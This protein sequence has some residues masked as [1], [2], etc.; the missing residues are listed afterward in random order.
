MSWPYYIGAWH[1][2][3]ALAVALMLAFFCEH[4]IAAPTDVCQ[5]QLEVFI[6]ETP[7]HLIGSFTMVVGGRIAARLAELEEIGLNPRGYASADDT[8][9]LD[10]LVGL[11]YR[12]EE[13]SQ[14]IYIAAPD[15]LRAAKTLDA[16]AAP[17]DQIA[18]RTDYGAVLNYT[19]FSA[20]AAQLAPRSF[21]FNGS[22]ATLDARV[23]TPFGTLS[24]T[25]I[26]RSAFDS[27]FDALRL[28]TAF[29]YSDRETLT[30]YRAGDAITGGL[31]WTRPIRIG[32]LQAQRNFALRPDLVTLPLPSASG[33]AAVPST[34][35][36]FVNNVKTSSQDIESGPYR[37]SNVP[38]A[39]GSGEAR[40]VVRDASGRETVTNL[41][42][43]V[44]SRLLGA[45][46]YDFSVEAG[47]PRV[48]Y[49]TIADTYVKQ[50]VMSGS[51]RTGILDWLTLEGHAEAGAGLWNAGAGA[52]LRTGSF[53]VFSAA[54]AGSHFEGKYGLQSYLA[55][56]FGVFGM[57]IQLSSQRSFGSYDDLASAT[58]RLQTGTLADQQT[59]L[60]GLS[61]ANRYG[62]GPA[63]AVPGSLWVS[64]RPPKALD[65]VSI[66][67]PL[68]FDFSTLSASF[69]H[70]DDATGKMSNI[71]SAS[72]SR[73]FGYSV[74]AFATAYADIKD[75]KNCGFLV[76]L[77]IPIGNSALVSSGISRDRN[78]SNVTT[79]AV[80]PL[81]PQPGS[82][83]WRVHDSEGATPDRSGAVAYRSDYARVEVGARQSG[84]GGSATGEVEGAVATMGN[85]I[86]LSNRIDDSFAVIDTGVPG[87]EV[88][89]ENRSVGFT[90]SNGRALI[91]SLHS[92]QKN[93]IAIDTRN[94]PVDAD[95]STTEEI[96]AP[97]DR[98]G[99]RLDFRVRTNTSAAILVLTGPDGQP[100][101]AGAQ[102][103]VEGGEGFVV[104]YD[105]RAWVKGLA[106]QNTVTV[107]LSGHECRASFAYSAQTNKQVVI[108]ARCQ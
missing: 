21:A 59:L 51:G 95:I 26:L 6:N 28:D 67:L 36:V 63:G 11:S 84:K 32:G 83:G 64:A 74:T 104:G 7:T 41:P 29:A 99:V 108:P 78:G 5:L 80:K 58:A 9:V 98:S 79:D 2:A 52:I 25:G 61:L 89:A 3:A 82:Y 46:L 50:F 18:V 43:Y 70:L 33:S 76:G 86:F 48:S 14:Q 27:R 96:V 81:G 77:S 38:A 85:G 12:Y 10:E 54:L 15:Q 94:L 90:D 106:P 97:A 103:K 105:G 100:I 24:Q 30:T 88:F 37:I 1:R 17:R 62:P 75:R 60:A 19:L 68:P 49:A 47:M 57:S 45:G 101:P 56:E 39:T 34:I 4:A 42:F 102:G 53:G 92:Y 13:A 35:D 22:S 69:I 8:I 40:V 87:V 107:E 66:G 73:G 44:S 31:A 55:Y 93:K 71:L 65:R 72:W 23:F 91:T 16:S 20:G